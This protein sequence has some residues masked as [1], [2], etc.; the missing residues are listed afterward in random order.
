MSVEA[1]KKK[2]IKI[3]IIIAVILLRVQYL[4]ETNSALTLGSSTFA[5][6]EDRLAEAKQCMDLAPEDDENWNEDEIAIG[7][8]I[9]DLSSQIGVCSAGTLA[10]YSTNLEAALVEWRP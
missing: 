9:E 7:D 4:L 2:K 6:F 10:T 8:I 3:R 1:P 5:V